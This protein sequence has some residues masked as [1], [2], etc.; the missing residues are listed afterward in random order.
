MRVP[1]VWRRSW[2]R[3]GRTPPASQCRLEALEQPR[4][5]DRLAGLGVREHEVVVVPVAASPGAGG[6]ARRRRRSRAGRCGRSAS[7]WA[8]RTRRG[9]S[10]GG[11][12]RAGR[13]N[14]CL[15]S[16]ARAAR[17]GAFRSSP[18]RGTSA[19]RPAQ[20]RRRAR[21]A[22]APRPP[23]VQGSGCRGPHRRT[24]LVDEGAGIGLDPFLAAC[25]LEDRVQN[26]RARSVSSWPPVRCGSYGAMKAS[27]LSSPD[28]LE[29]AGAEKGSQLDARRRS[30]RSRSWPA[31]A[32]SLAGLPDEQ[33]TSLLDRHPLP[34]ARR[35][36]RPKPISR[37]N[38]ASA[39]VRVR[40]SRVEGIRLGPTRRLTW[41]VPTHHL[42]YQVSRPAESRLTSSA[43]VPRG[44]RGPGV[45][46]ARSG[47][48]GRACHQTD[49]TPCLGR[50][51]TNQGTKL[52]ILCPT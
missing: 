28:P 42:P 1:N 37:R 36:A 3:T 35:V 21:L 4:A 18:R 7:T 12:A 48:R 50:Q 33:L 38:S 6:R 9:R 2:K 45:G 8:C 27:I 46:E 25:V 43:P 47:M 52:S 31:C 39:W 20:G 29:R 44:R 22:A 41:V 14:R 51:G 32:P 19:A 10:C 30:C 13:A 23:P 5:V 16:A 34:P 17:P 40:P 49:S 11:C 24:G 15:A 26:S